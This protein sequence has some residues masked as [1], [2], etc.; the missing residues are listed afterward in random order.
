[1]RKR[2][3]EFEIHEILR[4]LR[5]GMSMRQIARNFGVSRQAIYKILRKRNIVPNI[6]RPLW[7]KRKPKR[8]V[9]S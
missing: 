7:A 5:L 1:M 8:P 4:M 2:W 3:S 6:H 9:D